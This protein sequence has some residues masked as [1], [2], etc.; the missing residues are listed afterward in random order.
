MTREHIERLIVLHNTLIAA[1]SPVCWL[2][3]GCVACYMVLQAKLM[4]VPGTKD[5]A[6]HR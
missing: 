1:L 2:L 4:L 6:A 5:T 3:P